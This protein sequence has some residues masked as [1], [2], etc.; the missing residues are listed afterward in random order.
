VRLRLRTI[1]PFLPPLYTAPIA[2][3]SWD[4]FYVVPS[5]ARNLRAAV[6]FHCGG[7]VT[8][9]QAISGDCPHTTSPGLTLLPPSRLRVF[10]FR[11][12]HSLLRGRVDLQD[13]FATEK[14]CVPSSPTTNSPAPKS[15]ERTEGSDPFILQSHQGNQW[16]GQDQP[17]DVIID[18]GHVLQVNFDV[19][20]SFGPVR[21]E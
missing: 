20:R 19:D 18:G 9:V 16:I 6:S 8:G 3:S 4:G 13:Q 7:N 10:D 17:L 12:F 14:F 15:L 5:N 11:L 1:S 2:A 21:S